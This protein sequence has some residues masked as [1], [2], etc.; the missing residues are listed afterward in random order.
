MR[1]PTDRPPPA[2]FGFLARG[3][4]P[5]LGYAGT[6]D[7]KWLEERYPFL[8]L[9][10]DDRHHQGAPEDQQCD[11][12]R[13]GET[14]RLTNLTPEGRAEIK[15]PAAEIPMT[16]VWRNDPPDDLQPV[17]DTLILEP[18][19]RRVMVVWRAALKLTRKLTDVRE[20]CIGEL[21]PGR[22]RAVSAGKRYV[23][24]GA[25]R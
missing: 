8:P 12:L 24:K 19:H 25:V 16:V 9:D 7:K 20:V 21:T 2:G 1:S 6:Y 17:C 10:F 11:Y 3:W 5:R 18:D 15:L 13:G 22:Q 14:V 23:E 4:Q